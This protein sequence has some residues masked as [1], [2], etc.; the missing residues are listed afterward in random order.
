MINYRVKFLGLALVGLILGACSQTGTYETADLMNEQAADKSG[1]KMTP[2]GIG[3]ANASLS[4]CANCVAEPVIQS[5]ITTSNNN[6]NY[7]DVEVWND[8]EKL[9]IKVTANSSN[10]IDEIQLSYPF[11]SSL[12]GQAQNCNYRIN[13]NNTFDNGGIP[14]STH[15]FEFDL[16]E[17]ETDWNKCDLESFALRVAGISG[18]PVFLQGQND[19]VSGT[20]T[21]GQNTLPYTCNNVP[22]AVSY[23]LHEICS[24]CDDESFSY[25]ANVAGTD[26]VNVVFTY[27]AAEPLEDA[28][29]KFTFPQIENVSEDRIYTAPDGKEYSVNNDGNNTVLTWTGDIGCT[30][31]E[32]TS[33]VFEVMADCNA[34]GKAQIWTDAKVN[35][36]SVKNDNTPNIRF[37]CSDQSIEETN[38]ED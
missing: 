37:Y 15:T 27:D 3:N 1:F 6:D 20:Y 32:A 26:L 29:V 11:S 25:N 14:F 38:E 10:T 33:F 17:F 34:S 23:A 36:E 31:A 2:F 12:N 21:Q 35:G 7:A 24:G 30:D 16:G 18:Q 8:M 9:Y 28:E 5:F 19:T 22:T 4:T 13:Y